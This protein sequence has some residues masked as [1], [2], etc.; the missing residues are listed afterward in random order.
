MQ[1]S[2]RMRG[3]WVALSK[4]GIKNYFLIWRRQ[5]MWSQQVS[6][7]AWRPTLVQ[8]KDIMR[9]PKHPNW[10][11]RQF[12]SQSQDGSSVKHLDITKGDWW[13]HVLKQTEEIWQVYFS[14]L[15]PLYIYKL[16]SA[17]CAPQKNPMIVFTICEHINSP[18][19]TLLPVGYSEISMI[20]K[21]PW[22]H[23]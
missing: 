6:E 17:S 14:T 15:L 21:I 16:M 11:N 4:S 13:V 19:M 1:F 23:I 18:S 5:D 7:S 8:L 9:H 10:L 20:P 12:S 22:F 2:N 3:A